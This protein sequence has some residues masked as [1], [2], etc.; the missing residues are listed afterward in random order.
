MLGFSF[1]FKLDQGCCTVFVA[2]MSPRKL[3]CYFVLCIFLLLRLL[4]ISTNLPYDIG[5]NSVD[6]SGLDLVAT[7]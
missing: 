5:W 2:K 1:T 6:M 4:W 3:E 7:T